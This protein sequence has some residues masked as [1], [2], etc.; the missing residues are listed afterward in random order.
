MSLFYEVDEAGT[1]I[2]SEVTKKEKHH[3][4]TLMH[5]Y[6]IQKDSKEDPIHKSAKQTQM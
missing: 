4:S 1:Y 5:I 3:C 6:G 2:Q